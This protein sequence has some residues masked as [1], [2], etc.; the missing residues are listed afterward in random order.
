MALARRGL[1]VVSVDGSFYL[2]KGRAMPRVGSLI[3]D[4]C[5]DS[6]APDGGTGAATLRTSAP[7]LRH[8]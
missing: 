5:R 6:W 3:C 4:R 8:G 2:V 1:D 7:G